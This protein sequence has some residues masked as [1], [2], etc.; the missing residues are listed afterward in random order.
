MSEHGAQTA[1]S[2]G[3][4]PLGAHALRARRHAVGRVADVVLEQPDEDP[5]PPRA[6]RRS[7]PP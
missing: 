6:P 3:V 1:Y 2:L 5:V 7:A 4:E